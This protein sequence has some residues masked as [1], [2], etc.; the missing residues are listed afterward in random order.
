M[1]WRWDRIFDW[2]CKQCVASWSR[3]MLLS[4]SNQFFCRDCYSFTSRKLYDF[5]ETLLCFC[6]NLNIRNFIPKA[7]YCFI[8]GNVS[9]S[10][11]WYFEFDNAQRDKLPDYR[12]PLPDV[13]NCQS[14]TWPACA[15]VSPRSPQGAVRWDTLGTRL[16]PLFLVSTKNR[17]LWPSPTTEVRDS[18]TSRHYAHAL[19]QVWQIWFVLV[20]I[21]CV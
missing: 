6:I 10:T 4:F 3:I 11:A 12:G 16:A 17:N 20:S 14:G 13:F 19:S 8:A 1:L 7:K 9:L 18:R 21:Y 2:N 15:R 5:L